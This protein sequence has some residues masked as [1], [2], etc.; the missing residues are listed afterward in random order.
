MRLTLQRLKSTATATEGG[1]YI[2]GRWH[3][4]AL[5]D[6]VREIGPNGEGKIPGITAIPAGRYKVIIDLSN[7]FKCLMPHLMDVPH[8]EGVRIH[9][10][11][12]AAD[13][14][15]CILLGFDKG[16][17]DIIAQ[18]RPA[19]DAFMA[20]LRAGLAEGEVWLTILNYKEPV[21]T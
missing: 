9:S 14:E 16:G 12:T 18:S 8:F 11:N 20:R 7:R 6:P 21:I 4:F 17:P 10:G 1:F 15:G 5:E 3:S 19:F 13:T 2:D